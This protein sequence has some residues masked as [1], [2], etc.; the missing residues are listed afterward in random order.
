ME[1]DRDNLVM[2]E[3]EYD[4]IIHGD[5]DDDD[6]DDQNR[7]RAAN[8]SSF[9]NSTLILEPTKLRRNY[10]CH[11]V[12][13]C[14]YSSIN[15]REYLYHRRDFHNEK[16]QI[17][18]CPFCIYASKQP[19]KLDRHVG[20]V[21][22][23]LL[24]DPNTV[25]VPRSQPKPKLN[26]QDFVKRR[27][28]VTK[29]RPFA[30][31]G[32]DSKPSNV[33]VRDLIVKREMF[34][35]DSP[36]K[37]CKTPPSNMFDG[38]SDGHSSMVVD[39]DLASVSN[40]FVGDVSHIKLYHCNSCRYVAKSMALL[41]KHRR[42]HQL[43][44]KF[45]CCSQCNYVTNERARYTKHMKYHSL[46]KI[47]CHVCEFT[48]SYKW[49][50][51]RHMKN[52]TS[53]R[54][55]FR[56]DMCSFSSHTRQSLTVHTI[57]HHGDNN[58]DH[59]G[60]IPED[61]DPQIADEI[62]DI[63]IDD[64][65]TELNFDGELRDADGNIIHPNSIRRGDYIFKHGKWYKKNLKCKFCSYRAVWPFSI[66]KHEQVHTSGVKLSDSEMNSSGSMQVYVCR[67]CTSEFDDPTTLSR[68]MLAKHTNHVSS[69]SNSENAP[70]S[71][72]DAKSFTCRI[73]NTIFNDHGSHS[74]HMNTV[75][76]VAAKSKNLMSVLQKIQ[77]SPQDE[78]AEENAP[79]SEIDAAKLAHAQKVLSDPNSLVVGT[80]QEPY[81]KICG[82]KSK[83][84]SELEKHIRI[85]TLEKPFPCPYC[86]HSSRWKGDLKRHIFKLHPSKIEEFNETHVNRRKA[87]LPRP[88]NIV[89]YRKPDANMMVFPGMEMRDGSDDKKAEQN[90]TPE[91]MNV[92][93]GEFMDEEMQDE[94][95][96]EEMRLDV[97][98]NVNVPSPITLS[99]MPQNQTTMTATQKQPP[100]VTVCA[101]DNE[102]SV[103]ITNSNDGK[104]NSSDN[105]ALGSGM[106]VLKK[107]K[108]YI[109]KCQRCN[110]LSRTAS[111][112]HVHMVQHLNK[113][114]YMCS[115]CFYRSNWEWDITKHIKMKTQKNE[116]HTSAKVMLIDEAG[117][118][119]YDKY[120]RFMIE[121]EEEVAVD[122]LPTLDESSNPIDASVNSGVN[123][124]EK[125]VEN[126]IPNKVQVSIMY[127]CKMCNHKD[128]SKRAVIT[129]IISHLHKYIIPGR[130][131]TSAKTLDDPCIMREP[132]SVCKD[133]VGEMYLCKMC[134]YRTKKNF[135]I[136]FHVK[137]HHQRSGANYK[138]HFCPYWVNFRKTLLKH[139]KLHVE[140]PN[141]YLKEVENLLVIEAP[142]AQEQTKSLPPPP[143]TPSITPKST[144][145]ATSVSV[146]E[147][148]SIT[149]TPA[150]SSMSVTPISSSDMTKKLDRKKFYCE[151]CP[152]ES[153]NRTQYL[154]HKQF[155]RPNRPGAHKCRICSYS[156]SHLHLLRQHMKVHSQLPFVDMTP[157]GDYSDLSP[158]A[159]LSDMSRMTEKH[160]LQIPTPKFDI[161]VVNIPS[162]MVK[163]GDE[164]VKVFKC[165]YCPLVNK[166]RANIRVHEQ[167]HT[168]ENH[169]KF[170][171]PLCN[172]QCN[173]QG[174]LTAHIKIHQPSEL[175]AFTNADF[176]KKDS[177]LVSS[178]QQS[179]SFMASMKQPSNVPPHLL[180][181]MP[182]PRP[183]YRAQNYRCNK[184]PGIF[185]TQSDLENHVKFHG[186]NLPFRCHICDY[187]A[188]CKPH[189]HNHFRVHT[190]EHNLS[191]LDNSLQF[192]GSS[193]MMSKLDI[194]SPFNP[195][196]SSSPSV[197]ITAM[198]PKAS[199][200]AIQNNNNN[201]NYGQ[202]ALLVE[203]GN[204]CFKQ[205]TGQ[206]GDIRCNLCPAKFK[207]SYL[208]QFHRALHGSNGQYKCSKCSY[209]VSVVKNMVNHSKLHSYTISPIFHRATGKNQTRPYRCPNC[210]AMFNKVARFHR[211][212]ALHG[213]KNRY[214][215]DQC[216]YSV[217]FAAN[218]V[219]HKQIHHQNVTLTVPNDLEE[220]G[221][222]VNAASKKPLDQQNANSLSMFDGIPVKYMPNA[223]KTQVAPH[224]Q[225]QNK[226]WLQESVFHVIAE[227]IDPKTRVF[228]C[229]R[230]PYEHSRKD[231]VQNHLRRHV[232]Y[233]GLCC[234][235]CDYYTMHM[236]FMRDH[237]KLHFRQGLWMK[238][239]NYSNINN[240]K[241][242]ATLLS[243]GEKSIVFCDNGTDVPG[244][245][246]RFIPEAPNETEPP[247]ETNNL[248][249][250]FLKIKDE[251][252][253]DAMEDDLYQSDADYSMD[254][255]NE[256]NMPRFNGL[257]MVPPQNAVF[258]DRS[259]HE[260]KFMLLSEKTRPKLSVDSDPDNAPPRDYAQAMQN[261]ESLGF[262]DMI[263]AIDKFMKDDYVPVKDGVE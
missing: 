238:Q 149:T 9:V 223:Q 201:V 70:N 184:C 161:D 142:A 214:T 66:K 257:S 1:S 23:T 159:H 194:Q 172:Y 239:H 14:Y 213:V 106:T 189:L 118:K 85:H 69:N 131:I 233:Q 136:K 126:V 137:Q 175:A 160:S 148:V 19:Q 217:R 249:R 113:K 181:S 212:V 44:K 90:F 253:D 207:S 49:N 198:P 81:C 245:K 254:S 179:P 60:L 107:V 215:C 47:K 38:S 156:V 208:M 211:H 10:S 20:M 58:G 127:K 94:L 16:M 176:V 241:I 232:A 190:E 121:I 262:E 173:N 258:N 146:Q 77:K 18:E 216:D 240:V 192:D 80:I 219:K 4:G 43:K 196:S 65:S 140:N 54:G 93:E 109:Y 53:I 166:R 152:Y 222:E 55:I 35:V 170:V 17:Y 119:N 237:M 120:K 147:S 252:M 158:I 115:E 21:H 256:S 63:N 57:W 209:S 105:M 13:D 226:E 188:R 108:R 117:R 99:V 263:H 37:N 255:Y 205:I 244:E 154:Y 141:L 227:D 143:P 132:F 100:S 155:H 88:H 98:Y 224:Q 87:K 150:S 96:E 248:E 210:P 12:D 165:R 122:Q 73:C 134:P 27:K 230:C 202:N 97:N 22:K 25:Y 26:L 204:A 62:S 171:C 128:A 183:K 180:V 45:F 61:I 139:L 162:V 34:D 8:Q 242:T 259:R 231:A 67:M 177:V 71:T 169:S 76:K 103:S 200:N 83:Y 72:G 95:I 92:D 6:D 178:L 125:P 221:M 24:Q 199:E 74:K 220:D 203:E 48:T 191:K 40:R 124:Q 52:H 2:V 79:L 157:E 42:C 138:C 225:L 41:N 197:T 101:S 50:M 46:P 59:E 247:V 86:K 116:E 5:D 174:V 260:P 250:E 133:N 206:S 91:E 64:A 104:V 153:D 151:H 28:K 36:S 229:N 135:Y 110:F 31:Q 102:N 29:F 193:S 243:T 15:P 7:L 112:F 144:S 235:H 168:K 187:A 195:P 30:E 114:P 129:H 32:D 234:P 89:Q 163:Q 3:D 246:P 167:M 186:I 84:V 182:M 75:H 78:T 251:P 82:Y 68:H 261:V 185:K 218:L 111:R 130:G 228:R 123:G 145:V 11:G 33:V 164:M 236:C 39:Q 51:E 56:C